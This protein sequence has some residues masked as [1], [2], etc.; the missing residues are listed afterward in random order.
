MVVLFFIFTEKKDVLSKFMIWSCN[1]H[2]HHKLPENLL[3]HTVK[4]IL[5]REENN[6]HI[7][8]MIPVS[9]I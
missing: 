5:E 8:T 3:I 1:K 4:N 9:F 2:A 7:Q 6:D